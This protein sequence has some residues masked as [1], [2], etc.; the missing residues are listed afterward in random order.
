MPRPVFLASWE[1]AG[2]GAPPVVV[3]PD[4][5]HRTDDAEVAFRQRALELLVQLGLADTD[6]VLVPQ[7]RAT[8][9]VLA[10]ARR[11]VYSWNNLR[12]ASVQAAAILTAESGRDA[13]RLITD[14]EVIQLD[15]IRPQD[16]VE[17]LVDTLPT[18]PS[19]RIRPLCV[20]KAHYDD[21]GRDYRTDDPL[22]EISAQADELRHLMRAGR[23]AIH[24][25]YVATR[26]GIGERTR[27]T[28]LS[29]IDLTREG[30]IL[31][32]IND[33]LDGGPQI[34]LYPGRRDHLID[35]LTLTLNALG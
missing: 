2:L 3:E 11:E 22:N 10:T 21:A 30:R 27:S 1:L 8:L 19:A 4:H 20:P 14:H 32:F 16:L 24:Q 17:S 9:G 29:T 28:P 35:A 23:D 5:T 34:N 7:Y 6:G 18:R 31:S 15:P 33:G 26:Q 25:L 12:H 13:V